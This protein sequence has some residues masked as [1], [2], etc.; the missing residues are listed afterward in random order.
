MSEPS[1]TASEHIR[2][3]EVAGVL[4]SR[5]ALEAAVDALLSE[6]FDRA[7]IDLMAGIDAV[8]ER[9]G[10]VYVPAEE[11]ADVP[12]IPRRAFVARED[13]VGAL[14]GAA[15]IL[16][17]VGAT[18]AALGVVA[19]GGAL[20]L[21]VAAAAAGGAA[22]AGGAGAL[23]ARF[24]GQEQSKELEAQMATGGLVLWARVRSPD[25]E[26]KAQRVLKDHGA[27]AVRTHE[28]EIYKRFEDI[29]LSSLVLDPWLGSE[30]LGEPL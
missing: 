16:T 21:A 24:I 30:P 13:I 5:E 11:L 1:D 7:D 9:L 12:D 27:E 28:I 8:R 23:I 22:T 10:T 14:T 17:F 15:G 2:V 29:P 25:R 3:R 6:G 18:A 26:E 4:R 20:A 19:S